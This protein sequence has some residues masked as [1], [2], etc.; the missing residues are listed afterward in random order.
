MKDEHDTQ[1]I[2]MEYLTPFESWCVGMEVFI[3]D[4]PI[5][6]IEPEQQADSKQRTGRSERAT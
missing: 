3:D 6:E 5:E 2:E 4:L 1:T